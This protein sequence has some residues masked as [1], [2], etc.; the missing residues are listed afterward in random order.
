MANEKQFCP[1]MMIGFDPPK[2]DSIIDM[3]LCNSDCAWYDDVEEQCSIVT[4]KT[5]V[6]DMVDY[7]IAAINGTYEDYGDI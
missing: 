2:G 7:S 3:R 1:I 6:A 4:L 5:N